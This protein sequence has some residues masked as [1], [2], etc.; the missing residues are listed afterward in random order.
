[1]CARAIKI[2]QYIDE[3][4]RMEIGRRGWTSRGI[5]SS[6]DNTLEIDSR[7][8][9]KLQLSPIEWHHLKLITDLLKQFKDATSFLSQNHKP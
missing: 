5:V 2:Q 3:W 4:L 8:I 6:S 1:M 7:D 9:R